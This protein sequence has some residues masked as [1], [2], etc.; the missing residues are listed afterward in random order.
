MG[1]HMVYGPT[2][3]GGYSHT[4]IPQTFLSFKKTCHKFVTSIGNNSKHV[5]GRRGCWL[6]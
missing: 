3:Y 4:N 6:G 2:M 1:N 5:I